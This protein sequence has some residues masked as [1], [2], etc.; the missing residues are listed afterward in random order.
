M[1]RS[2][3]SRCVSATAAPRLRPQTAGPVHGGGR[4]LLGWVRCYL[5]AYTGC[6]C[7][8]AGVLDLGGLLELRAPDL[9][10]VEA[11]AEVGTVD[12]AVVPV[13][14]PGTAAVGGTCRRRASLPVPQLTRVRRVGEVPHRDAAH[15]P[16]LHHDVAA[17]DRHQ[18]AV[19]RDAVLR[20]RLGIAGVVHPRDLVVA[21]ERELTVHP[22]TLDVVDAVG[23]S[24]RRHA[25]H[26]V[27]APPP[28]ARR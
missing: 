21:L 14:R 11:L 7:T 27:A 19:V 26:A 20:P 22:A 5:S 16:G 23:A 10:D 17:L 1:V 25:R 8:S 3:R 4:V 12:V 15:V 2:A 9:Q 18:G 6:V 28:P 13:G 24:R